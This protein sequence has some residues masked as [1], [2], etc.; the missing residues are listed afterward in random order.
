M[1]DLVGHQVFK[2]SEHIPQ[3]LCSLTLCSSLLPFEPLTQILIAILCYNVHIMCCLVYVQQ[4]QDIGVAQFLH[5]V[6]LRL[7]VLDIVL[8]AEGEFVDDFNGHLL[9]SGNMLS[10]ED[11]GG[12]PTTNDVLTVVLVL[13]YFFELSLYPSLVFPL[14]NDSYVC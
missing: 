14:H 3:K 9:P 2:P 7:N 10:Q 5:D 11:S 12:C 4:L 13:V 8:S 6:N 1:S